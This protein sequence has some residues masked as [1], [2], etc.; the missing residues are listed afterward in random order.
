MSRLQQKLNY[1]LNFS[2]MHKLSNTFFYS[3]LKMYLIAIKLK[4]LAVEKMK[5]TNKKN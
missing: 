5:T 3:L 4:N 2:G 1:V